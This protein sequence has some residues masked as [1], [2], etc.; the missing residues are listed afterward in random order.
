MQELVRFNFI[1][2]ESTTKGHFCVR[3]ACISFNTPRANFPTIPHHKFRA[4][5][6]STRSYR[7]LTIAIMIAFDIIA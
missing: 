2:N 4:F 3:A 5:R 7:L 1:L 6:M